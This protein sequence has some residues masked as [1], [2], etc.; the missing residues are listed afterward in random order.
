MGKP[1]YIYVSSLLSKIVQDY[2]YCPRLV[3]ETMILGP[4]DVFKH[5]K[6]T[7]THTAWSST[8]QNTQSF[9]DGA[10]RNRWT[11]VIPLQVQLFLVITDTAGNSILKINTNVHIARLIVRFYRDKPK[12]SRTIPKWNL[13]IMLHRLTQPPFEP[14][15]E[16]ALKFLTWK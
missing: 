10:Q 14:Q 13:S 7:T 2:S 15:E 4:G 1:G 9:K 16:A 12:S 3:D 6:T 5:T 8:P 11:S